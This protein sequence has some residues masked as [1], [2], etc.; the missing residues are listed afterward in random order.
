MM[1]DAA[2]TEPLIAVESVGRPVAISGL[3][4]MLAKLQGRPALELVSRSEPSTS[5]AD[6]TR[7]QGQVSV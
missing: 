2:H 5:H 1:I 4:R 6:Q 3:V 7:E